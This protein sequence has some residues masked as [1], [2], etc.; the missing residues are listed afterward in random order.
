VLINTAAQIF[1]KQGVMQ[2]G[3]I[4]LHWSH[5]WT[6]L[7]RILHNPYLLLGFGCYVLSVLVWLVVLSKADVS[8]AYPLTSLGYIFTGFAGWWILNEDVNPIR[9]LGIFI[10]ILGVFFITRSSGT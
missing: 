8:Y 10:I 3:S 6:I 2:L 4:S 9:I 1:L 5:A 7:V